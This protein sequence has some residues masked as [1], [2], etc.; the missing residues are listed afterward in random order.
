MDLVPVCSLILSFAE[1]AKDAEKKA[2]GKTVFTQSHR[3][4]LGRTRQTVR[5]EGIS[6][7]KRQIKKQNNLSQK[8][9]QYL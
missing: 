1:H 8:L 7:D 9:I 6:A 2:K 4:S 3:E 5:R